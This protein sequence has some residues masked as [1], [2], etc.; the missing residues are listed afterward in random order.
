MF[1]RGIEESFVEEALVSGEIIEE[2]LSDKP[3]ASFL[4]FY[5]KNGEVVHVVYSRDENGNY[6]IITVYRPSLEKW[7]DDYKTRRQL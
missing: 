4:L 7:L 1:Q 5:Y 3:Y 6:V 2:Y